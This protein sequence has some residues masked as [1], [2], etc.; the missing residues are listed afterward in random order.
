MRCLSSLSQHLFILN[1]II[2][3][4][5]NQYLGGSATG[6]FT[7]A[8]ATFLALRVRKRWVLP[9]MFSIYSLFALPSHLLVGDNRYL[10]AAAPIVLSSSVFSLILHWDSRMRGLTIG[11]LAFWT[12]VQSSDAVLR[13]LS[14]EA[15]QFPSIV[16]IVP[17][18]LGVCIGKFLHSKI[19]KH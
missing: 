8:A 1:N 6:L 18:G 2:F 5:L 15:M 13:V 3:A 7:I 12:L 4:R 9:A 14:G 10:I 16:S 17:G 11:F 19:A